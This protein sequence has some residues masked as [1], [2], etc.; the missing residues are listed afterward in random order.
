VF[1][2]SKEQ[3]ARP[4][5][6]KVKKGLTAEQI[7]RMEAENAALEQDFRAVERGYGENN[8]NFTV[9][10]TYVK[11]LIENVRV[12]KFLSSRYPELLTEFETIVA[13]DVI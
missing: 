1:G 4:D 2:S 13:M 7:A 11:K 10:K 9:T 6:P 3:L 5:E 12:T 8:L